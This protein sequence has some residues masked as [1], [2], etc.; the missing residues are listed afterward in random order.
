MLL[1]NGHRCITY[2]RRGFGKFS[3]PTTGYGYHTSRGRSQGAARPSRST[4]TWCTPPSRWAPRGDLLPWDLRLGRGQQ[5]DAAR[6]DPAA[7]ASEQPAAHLR[8]AECPARQRHESSVALGCLPEPQRWG[9]R[10][11]QAVD[12]GQT[13]SR[14]RQGSPSHRAH[15]TEGFPP[16]LR[17]WRGASARHR[18]PSARRSRAMTKVSPRRTRASTAQEGF[19]VRRLASLKPP[20]SSLD[21]FSAN[22]GTAPDKEPD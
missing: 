19:R 6:R 16:R 20:V 8:T 14:T 3:Q 5:G 1:V 10:G 2:D 4:R 21:K 18:S 22:I 17:R 11:L 7:F 15:T 13:G 9:E 12:L